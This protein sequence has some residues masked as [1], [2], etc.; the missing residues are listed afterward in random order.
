MGKRQIGELQPCELVTT[1][2]IS[3][4]A[5]LPIQDTDMPIL[6]G[7]LPIITLGALEIAISTLTLKSVKFRSFFYGKPITIIYDG[8]IDQQE[9]ARAR[10]SVD[11]LVEA[12]RSEGIANIRDIGIAVLETNGNVSVIDKK[13]ADTAHILVSD[14]VFNED[15][16]QRL[17][18]S[19][20]EVLRAVKEKN[21]KSLFL[22]IREKDGKYYAVKKVK[23]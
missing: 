21:E 17:K 9:M 1:I 14:G 5:S 16:L 23:T 8:K 2:L 4:L 18:L 19:K 7:I 22:V 11:D 15:S 20:K 10:I 12:M 6:H 13:D 3:E